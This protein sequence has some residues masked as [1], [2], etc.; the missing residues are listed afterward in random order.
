MN[1]LLRLLVRVAV[2]VLSLA[3]LVAYLSKEG[4]RGVDV[5]AGIAIIVVVAAN[6]WSYRKR[7][8]FANST[9]LRSRRVQQLG[10]ILTATGLIAW[11]ALDQHMKSW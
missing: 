1:P 10:L 2:A 3:L 11:G 8:P 4:S 6:E 5:T 9:V 7:Q